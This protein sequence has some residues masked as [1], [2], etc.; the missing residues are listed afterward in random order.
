MRVG[1]PAEIKPGE[2]RVGLTPTAVREYVSRGHSVLVQAGAGLGAG[3]GDDGYRR[4][5]AD[6][7]R[8]AAE[9]FEAAELVV[10]VKEPQPVEWARLA[11][12]AARRVS[13]KRRRPLK[14]PHKGP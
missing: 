14:R 4:A 9:V 7:A 13:A 12:G 3:Y 1:V 10:K 2:H 8:D 6:I 11:L 5:G